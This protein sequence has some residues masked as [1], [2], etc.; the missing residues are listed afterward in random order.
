[1]LRRTRYAIH[2]I[3]YRLNDSTSLIFHLRPQHHQYMFT[4]ITTITTINTM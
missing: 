4:T 3:I 1:M 2:I